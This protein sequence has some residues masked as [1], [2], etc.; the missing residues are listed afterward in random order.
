MTPTL[1]VIRFGP[2]PPNR[3]P[4]G[5]VSCTKNTGNYWLVRFGSRF[6]SCNTIANGG[7]ELLPPVPSGVFYHGRQW[8]L[9]PVGQRSLGRKAG[10][11]SASRHGD[12]QQH[13]AVG[14]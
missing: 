3:M 11:E 2:T 10:R 14:S 13:K 7:R 4:G 8:C 12:C 1:Q 9:K 5:G 6:M